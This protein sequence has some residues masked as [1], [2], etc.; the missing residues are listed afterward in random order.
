MNKII[1]DNNSQGSNNSLTSNSDNVNENNKRCKK[2]S[3]KKDM[4]REE[5]EEIIKELNE[6]MGI[7]E[8]KKNILL[9]ELEKNEKI[10][11]YLRENIEKIKKYYKC[12]TWGYFSD[13]PKKGKGNEISLL[14][15]IYKNDNYDIASKRIMCEKEGIKKSR[16]ELLF[17][18][19]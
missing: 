2:R 13:E 12:G 16:T 15:A 10:K 4:Y 7:N 8:K 5:R 11:K 19:K 3:T 9:Y 14:K 18:K 6:I 1:E 17:I